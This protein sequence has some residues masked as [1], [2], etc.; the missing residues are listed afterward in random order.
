MNIATDFHTQKKTFYSKERH[1]ESQKSPRNEW[2]NRIDWQ[3]AKWGEN[4][5]SRLIRAIQ[6]Q[7]QQ[8]N[9]PTII[10]SKCVWTVKRSSVCTIVFFLYTKKEKHLWSSYSKPIKINNQRTQ[11]YRF[12]VCRHINIYTY[13][14]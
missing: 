2:V 14:S 10:E 8:Q 6:Q 7:Q 11:I 13:E 9:T 1:K 12:S 3:S 5:P 4:Q